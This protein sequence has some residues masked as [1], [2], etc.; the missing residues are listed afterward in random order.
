[1]LRK[2]KRHVAIWLVRLSYWLSPRPV[3]MGVGF[4]GVSMV[5]YGGSVVVQPSDGRFCLN[6]LPEASLELYHCDWADE[7]V[8]TKLVGPPAVNIQYCSF[9]SQVT[10]AC[11]NMTPRES[12]NDVPST[13]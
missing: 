13:A 3:V 11:I 9:T 6:L 8:D 12:S 4:K 10:C 5:S 1:M 7:F 2:I